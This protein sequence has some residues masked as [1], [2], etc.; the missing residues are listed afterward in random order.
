MIKKSLF[1]GEISFPMRRF[2]AVTFLL[3]IITQSGVIDQPQPALATDTVTLIC[4]SNDIQM[5]GLTFEPGGIILTA[6]DGAGIWVYNIDRTS[7]YPLPETAP[8]GYSCHLSNDRQW[9]TYLNTREGAVGKMR[10]DGTQ[11]ATLAVYASEVEWWSADTF[12]VW[13]PNHEAYLQPDGSSERNAINVRGIT[14][15]QPGGYWGVRVEQQGDDF[16]RS[17][18]NLSADETNA[19]ATDAVVLAPQIPYFNASAWSPNGGWLAYVAQGSF[20]SVD[21]IAG[22][23]IFGIHPG[24]AEPQQW[25]NLTTLYGATRING[26]APGGL[27]WSRDGT[28]I[29]FW[30]IDLTG[31]DP[32]ADAGSAVIHILD[33]QS[34]DLN[35][36]CGFSTTEH[37]PNPPRL[38]W[39]PDGTHLAFGGNV[40]EDDKPNLLLALD[41][42]TGVFTELSEG[43]YPA[44][45][46]PDVIAWGTTGS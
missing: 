17:L 25:T 1:I 41:I 31:S 44:L 36:Y 28:R 16:I 35:V 15:I 23:E 40:I 3:F 43:V 12:L 22:A 30:V 42:E 2:V 19:T 34:G 4:P 24:D 26:H 18:V 38:V 37:T 9:I 39:S 14:S 32:I 20:D 8:C 45:G 10:L 5:R 46:N 21:Q 6:F 29:A 27:S 7:R 33:I 11:R 13:T